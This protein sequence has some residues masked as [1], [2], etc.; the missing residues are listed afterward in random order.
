MLDG[1]FFICSKGGSAQ[2]AYPRGLD[3]HGA[4]LGEVGALEGAVVAKDQATG[5]AV[6]LGLDKRERARALCARRRGLVA[7]PGRPRLLAH[8][9]V[10]ALLAGRD[11]LRLVPRVKRALAEG[12][13]GLAQLGHGVAARDAGRGRALAVGAAILQPLALGA[14]HQLVLLEVPTPA[15]PRLDLGADSGRRLARQTGRWFCHALGEAHFVIW[16]TS[17][18]LPPSAQTRPRCPSSRRPATSARSSLPT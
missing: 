6:V 18:R 13:K 14:V 8:A 12:T 7:G 3:V 9:V 16:P 17:T 11:L 5:A 1:L 10:R 2:V 15:A 4:H